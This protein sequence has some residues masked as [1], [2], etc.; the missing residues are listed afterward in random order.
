HRHGHAVDDAAGLVLGPDLTAALLEQT[1]ALAA[2]G[3]HPGQYYR[4]D[5]VAISLG[6][7]TEGDVHRGLV[8]EPVVT[9]QDANAAAPVDHHLLAARRQQ[10][11]SRTQLI[12]ILGF[13]DAY[14][15]D[16]VQPLGE[17]PGEGCGHVLDQ[18]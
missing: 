4:Q 5:L 11:E 7:G 16:L 6:R 9:G 3:A 17:R 18:H 2:V 15:A 14:T 13:L 10:G 12:A 1:R 8:V